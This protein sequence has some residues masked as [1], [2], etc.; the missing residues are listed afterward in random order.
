MIDTDVTDLGSGR[1]F[2][3]AIARSVPKVFSYGAE[4]PYFR[5]YDA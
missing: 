1:M 4:L 2:V 5:I 3:R